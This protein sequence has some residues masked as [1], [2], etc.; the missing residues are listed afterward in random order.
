MAETTP[1]TEPASNQRTAQT[2]KNM[3][4]ARNDSSISAMRTGSGF[5]EDWPVL[6]GERLVSGRDMEREI[7][8]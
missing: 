3:A 1:K 4:G 8:D 6:L 7:K 5:P 2:K